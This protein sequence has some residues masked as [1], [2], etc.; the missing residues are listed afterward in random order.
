MNIGE[1]I[2]KVR[3]A[4]SGEYVKDHCFIKKDNKWHLFSISGGIGKSWEDVGHEERISHS[5]SSDLIDWQLIGHPVEASRHAGYNDEHMAVAPFIIKNYDD[6]Y[7]M[8]YSGWRHP[9]KRPSFSWDGNLQSIYVATSRNLNDW[10]IP[11]EIRPKGIIVDGVPIVGRDPHVIRDN[12]KDRW[13][14][15]Y[16][17]AMT[18]HGGIVGVAESTDLIHWRNMGQALNA[19]GYTAAYDPAESPFV[20]RHPN[21][22]RYLMLLNWDYSISDDPSRF[23]SLKP[24]PFSCGFEKKGSEYEGVGLGFA[25]EIINHNG[26]NY[27]SGV[28]G[29]FGQFVIGFTAFSWTDDFFELGSH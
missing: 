10:E 9:H 1:A 16:T 19:V 14:L 13:L 28:L 5:V 24:I 4:P 22:D 2:T 18:K 25:R 23:D 29:R 27:M 12:D 26:R 6:V 17:D 20:L 8:F 21:S 15:Y 7:Y 3:Y 11:E